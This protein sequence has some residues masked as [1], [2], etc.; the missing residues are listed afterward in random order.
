MKRLF[1]LY[2]HPQTVVDA[3]TVS[4][5][6]CCREFLNR[7]SL[8]SKHDCFC[9]DSPPKLCTENYHHFLQDNTNNVKPISSGRGYLAEKYP[10]SLRWRRESIPPVHTKY[11]YNNILYIIYTHLAHQ[12][13]NIN[14]VL[15]YPWLAVVRSGKCYAIIH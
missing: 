7:R 14:S 11:I 9:E 10:I 6:R 4:K 12:A 5:D 2:I 3:E 1:S 15:K 8:R 13:H